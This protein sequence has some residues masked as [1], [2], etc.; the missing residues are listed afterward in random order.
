MAV[1]EGPVGKSKKAVQL[2]VLMGGCSQMVCQRQSSS[3]RAGAILIVSRFDEV[4]LSSVRAGVGHVW[5]YAEQWRR[6][7][8]L[9]VERI[10]KLTDSR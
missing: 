1:R 10:L 3:V 7:N 2:F 9:S 5:K 4:G 6:I 8:A